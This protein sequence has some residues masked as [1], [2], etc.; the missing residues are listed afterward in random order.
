MKPRTGQIA[1][2]TLAG[3]LAWGAGIAVHS[4]WTAHARFDRQ[5]DEELWSLRQQ[6]AGKSL[7]SAAARAQYLAQLESR[8]DFARWEAAA[9]LGRWADRASVGALVVAMQDDAGT[10]RTC[11]IAQSLGRV[12]SPEA[13]PAL[14]QAIQHPRNLDLRVC[15][16]HALAEIGDGRA[17]EPLELQARDRSLVSDDRVSAIIALGDLGFPRALPA[18]RDLAANDP[19]ERLR[20]LAAAAVRKIDILHAADPVVELLAAWRDPTPWVAEEWVLRELGRRW[21]PRVADALN[22]FVLDDRRSVNQVRAA[23]LLLHHGAL[24]A[25]TT[26]ALARSANQQHQ[27]LAAYALAG[28]NPVTVAHTTP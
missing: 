20:R 12:G 25:E 21:D 1:L 6:S 9:K 22:S 2:A 28:R 27:W 7:L 23:A 11:V 4:A 24:R 17:L 5:L 8:N 10:R 19:D 3:L 26:Q 15:A 14:V 13:V 18:L 16:T